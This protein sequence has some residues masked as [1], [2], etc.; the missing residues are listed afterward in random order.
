MDFY[1]DILRKIVC[2]LFDRLHRVTEW[3]SLNGV[4]VYVFS[5]FLHSHLHGFI[6]VSRVYWCS[7]I[8]CDWNIFSVCELVNYCGRYHHIIAVQNDI[9]ILMI[10]N[11]IDCHKPFCQ[12]AS[13]LTNTGYPFGELIEQTLCVRAY[14]YVF[15][16]V[17]T[18]ERIFCV[19]SIYSCVSHWARTGNGMKKNTHTHNKRSRKNK[20]K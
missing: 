7:Y 20:I 18:E 6:T 15:G 4:T 13:G 5:S 1:S 19:T 11:I 10:V 3:I 16:A 8:P 17:K 9:Y 2:N 12:D 14:V